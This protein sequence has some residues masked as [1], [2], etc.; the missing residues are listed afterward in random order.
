[1]KNLNTETNEMGSKFFISSIKV[2]VKK[3]WGCF[4]STEKFHD[5]VQISKTPTQMTY[6]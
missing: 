1:M 2:S 4:G 3:V 6:F 5:S